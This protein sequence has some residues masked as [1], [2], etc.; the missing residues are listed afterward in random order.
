[1]LTEMKSLVTA[2]FQP[3]GVSNVSGNVVPVV[4][5]ESDIPVDGKDTSGAWKLK[6]E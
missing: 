3:A 2:C 4:S 6:I 1:M 5:L